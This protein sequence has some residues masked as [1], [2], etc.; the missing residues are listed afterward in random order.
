MPKKRVLPAEQKDE[1]FPYPSIKA[2]RIAAIDFVHSLNID[3]RNAMDRT[4]Q[5]KPQYPVSI[6]APELRQPVKPK[7]CHV[8]KCRE[9]LAGFCMQAS[10]TNYILYHE[11]TGECTTCGV[12][13]S[14]HPKCDACGILYGSRHR[15]LGSHYRGRK[16]CG[17]CIFA[18]KLLDKEIGRETT[19]EEFKSPMLRLWKINSEDDA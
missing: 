8:E 10:C 11:E 7:Q 2:F 3:G 17:Y 9:N 18:W 16:L 1:L 13:M 12:K 15:E 14:S 5:P 19:Y 6:Q 4:E